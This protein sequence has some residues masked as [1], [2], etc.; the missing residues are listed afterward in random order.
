MYFF[1]LFSYEVE[2]EIKIDERKDNKIVY[3][4][5]NKYN[6]HP[7]RKNGDKIR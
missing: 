3:F 4:N 5:K 7:F 2:T 6:L 1:L